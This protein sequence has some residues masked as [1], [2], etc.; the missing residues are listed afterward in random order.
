M[1]RIMVKLI[2]LII[3]FTV[4]MF[5]EYRQD[6]M[7]LLP[8]N[9]EK[10]IAN[11]HIARFINHAIDGM[12]T[13]FIEDQYSEIG[14]RAYPPKMLLKVLVYGYTIG[15]RSSRKLAD[16]LK[17]DLVFMWLAG[18]LMPDFR[19]ISDF[20]KD[21]LGDFKKIFEQVLH[22]CF[23]LGMMRVGKV[24]VDGTK[25]LANVS[26]H[27]SVYRKQL[28]RREQ[29]ICDKVD[30]IIREAEEIDREEDELY[31]NNTPHTTGKSFDAKEVDKKLKQL[32][33]KKKRLHKKHLQLEARDQE[34]RERK[35]KM[36]KDRNSYSSI[37][38]DATVMLIK[39]GYVAPGYN[40][41]LATEHQV[42]LG[43]TLSSNR[44]DTKLMKPVIKEVKDRTGRKP[45]IVTADAGYGVKRTYR[46]LK[47]EAIAAFIPYNNYNKEITLRN[48]GLY[49]APKQLD[50]EYERY[51]FKMMV[52]L[53]SE[54]GKAL[55]KRR[56]EDVEPVIG[57]LKRN[58]G[59]RRFNLRGRYKCEIELGLL[60]VGHNIKKI[61]SWVKKLIKWDDGRIKTQ[62]F[63]QM[64]GIS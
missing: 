54:E 7:Q 26:R 10:N 6:Q 37:D 17:E 31:G 21:K 58:M 49:E 8:Q 24:S 55:M 44:T 18:R 33:Q 11:D 36:R 9:L 2:N 56:R 25:F 15:I 39:E 32:N 19:T 22:T 42:I 60:S 28:A 64:M 5:K 53:R 63:A 57:D 35:K 3:N 20:R 46:Y 34:I 40:A 52:R 12:D 43:Y 23:D 27:K 45:K 29:Q 13:S 47:K 30:Q 14:Q 61:K 1:N 16:R 48:K 50:K 62:E 51:K 59:F 38:K 4:S 41:Q